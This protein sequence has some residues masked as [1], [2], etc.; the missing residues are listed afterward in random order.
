MKLIALVLL[1]FLVGCQHTPTPP[2]PQNARLSAKSAAAPATSLS[3]T[4]G[5]QFTYVNLIVADT[6]GFSVL[7]SAQVTAIKIEVPNPA[8][9]HF[10]ISASEDLKQWTVLCNGIKLDPVVIWDMDHNNGKK[11]FYRIR[12]DSAE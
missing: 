3:P 8:K 12:V 4:N 1:L 10:E 11:Y 9:A 5:P 2:V 6:D 7:G